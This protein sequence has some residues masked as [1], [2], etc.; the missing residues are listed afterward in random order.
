[1]HAQ[2]QAAAAQAQR[3][4]ARMAGAAALTTT[5]FTLSGTA[6]QGVIDEISAPADGT[7]TGI[8]T[9]RLLQIV[10]TRPQF[11]AKPDAATRPVVAALSANWLLTEVRETPLHYI[12]L[13]RPN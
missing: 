2:L 4:L 11:A 3:T 9:I 8:E 5:N 12:L 1:M 7:G 13:A 6:Y 10:A